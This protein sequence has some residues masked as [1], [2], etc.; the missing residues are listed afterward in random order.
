M[1]I[2]KRISEILNET[3]ED[4]SL[5]FGAVSPPIYQTS[6][7]CFPDVGTM[8]AS[9][10]HELD[11]PFYT[12]G[13]NPTVEI[14][15]KKLAELEGAED[16]L[17]F[18]SGS[19]A[20][21]AAVFHCVS[22]GDHV[23]CVRKPYS[24][25]DKLLNNLLSRY[26]VD[27]TMIPGTNPQEWIDA[28]KPNTKLFFLESPNSMT[29]EL[30]DIEAVSAIARQRGIQT[31]MD[32]SYAT[33]LNQQPLKLG[34]D[35]V[36]HSA[37]KYLAGHSDM[38]AGVLC[39]TRKRIEKIFAS[40]FMTFGGIISPNDAWLMIRGLRTL[41]IRMERVSKT[42]PAIVSWLENHPLVESIFYPHS[43]SHPQYNLAVKQQKN[44]GG[45]FSILLRAKNISEVEKFCNALERF[46]LAC[47]WGGYESLVFPVC[48]LYESENYGNTP[49]PWNMLRLY[50][51]LEEPES[52]LEDLERGFSAMKE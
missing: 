13:N 50:I 51:G 35:I 7:F 26:G 2:E 38:V 42:T 36:V 18:A 30:Q 14:L 39:T 28:A 33:P 20:I 21:A 15:R 19:A 12:R 49:L 8:R 41:A 37:S 3:G 1:D 48:A 6:N 43:A 16:A 17:V 32:N 34:V 24:W 5:H 31:I 11:V 4:R 40:E 9:V 45:Q 27:T 22:S 10:Q 44:P 25:T 52:L 46:L 23:V 29:F 47:S